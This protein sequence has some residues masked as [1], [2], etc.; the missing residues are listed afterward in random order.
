MLDRLLDPGLSLF[1]EDGYVLP[2]RRRAI[3][4]AAA[5]CTGI[6]Y[7]WLF[8]AWTATSQWNALPPATTVA[9]P[10]A[11]L[12]ASTAALLIAGRG[13]TVAAA[14]LIAGLVVTQLLWA[15]SARFL[16]MPAVVCL[17]GLLLSRR[18]SVMAAV[19]LSLQ[20][21]PGLLVALWA[22]TGAVW[23]STDWVLASMHE[24]ADRQRGALRLEQELL[25]RREELR[26]LN[27]SLRNAYAV[28]ERANHELAEARDEAE[29][30]R[31][32]KAQFAA[33]ISHELRTPLNLILGFAQVM[34]KTPES[35]PGATF[36]PDL[37]GDLREVCRAATHLL[38]LVDDV[39]DL[40]RVSQVRLALVLEET[41][42]IDIMR[43]AATT[44]AGLFRG[45][46]TL[47]CE[48]PPWLPHC[49]LDRTR[50][51]QVFINLLTNAARFTERGEVR[52]SARYDPAHDEVIAA[53]RDT[54]RGISAED[55]QRL[56]DPF[57]QMADP[58]HRQEGGTGLGLAICRTFV[59]MHGGRIW[60]RSVPGSGS[61]FSFA[62]PVK[63][64]SSVGGDPDWHPPGGIDHFGDSI[65]LV[66]GDGEA[67]R[68]LQRAL[69]S[70]QVHR[71]QGLD[72]VA[73]CVDQW[74]PKAVVMFGDLG[75]EVTLWQQTPPYHGLPAIQC[76]KRP[77]A[78]GIG[79]AQVRAV[80][81]KPVAAER[82][83]A[84]VDALGKVGRLLLVDDDEGMTRFLQRVITAAYPTTSVMAVHD[85]REALGVMQ[86]WQPSALI[87][88]LMM[89]HMS[90]AELLQLMAVDDFGD[91]PTVILTA[92]DDA[93]QG[94]SLAIA[95]MA[96]SWSAGISSTEA[97]AYL[98]AL[99]G[100]AHPRYATAGM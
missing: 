18:A 42:F 75:Q 50:I 69:P 1:S 19:A 84:A 72:E 99:A 43:E 79:G 87:L 13:N 100:I 55:Q 74:H 2:A 40:S 25:T 64:R 26:R 51:R 47:N 30:A 68:L 93:D 67:T 60:V 46:V 10:A 88:D 52:I 39:L 36:T 41:N 5:L 70:L 57:F 7:A 80:L 9:A 59:Q 22:T 29:E 81:R 8:V 98:E 24:A 56:F 53:V 3:R 16:T 32:L 31:R 58:S 94:D 4:V 12:I 23:L 28:L 44:V 45:G 83:L 21:E 78:G 61:E 6:A 15:D 85:A 76:A 48:E 17:A 86:S 90:G 73:D 20:A 97:V 77:S 37:V 66:D 62:V 65:V 92:M 27:D 33:A 82:L 35:Y 14:M 11:L 91:L 96:V 54:G 63:T 38:D 49:T 89:P 34:Y 71:C 95:E